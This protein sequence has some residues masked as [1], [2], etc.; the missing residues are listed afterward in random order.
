LRAT[1]EFALFAGGLKTEAAMGT[2]VVGQAK[3]ADDELAWAHA[4]DCA[5]DFLDDAAIFVA[6][7]HR[8]GDWAQSTERRL[9]R[10]IAAQ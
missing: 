8:R 7:R 2:G 9:A 1:H 4:G 5:A 3:G 10:T 6:H